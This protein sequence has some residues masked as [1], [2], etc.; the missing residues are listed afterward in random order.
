MKDERTVL[1][2][3]SVGDAEGVAALVGLDAPTDPLATVPAEEQQRILAA[4]DRAANAQPM[5]APS[6]HRDTIRREVA[7]WH[8]AHAPLTPSDEAAI[9]AFRAGQAVTRDLLATDAVIVEPIEILKQLP[10]ERVTE[11][12]P[13]EI[14]RAAHQIRGRGASAALLSE[15]V[16]PLAAEVRALRAEQDEAHAALD[17]VVSRRDAMTDPPLSLTSRGETGPA[18]VDTVWT[19]ISV[20]ARP[21]SVDPAPTW[22]ERA[23]E[24]HRRAAQPEPFEKIE[25]LPS[26]LTCPGCY[27]A[28]GS[29]AVS[30]PV[31]NGERAEIEV[32]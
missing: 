18:R 24:E 25:Q 15:L 12:E 6:V 8:A 22:G 30:G 9:L 19:G 27:A 1:D 13:A 28:T 23:I 20:I 5:I 11:A 26:G 7:A 31:P 21:A 4:A 32:P 14:E 29:P 10:A 3:A 16:P 2:V 17:P